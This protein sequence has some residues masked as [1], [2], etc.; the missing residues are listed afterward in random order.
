M[1]KMIRPV[2]AGRDD[3][4]GIMGGRLPIRSAMTKGQASD[5][6]RLPVGAGNDAWTELAMTD[7]NRSGEGNWRA[8][9]RS[10]GCRRRD[11]KCARR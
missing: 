10:S 11:G 1:T 8:G 3:D 2:R 7:A 5:D 4:S 9:G 6:E